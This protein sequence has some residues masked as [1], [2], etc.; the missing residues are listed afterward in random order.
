MNFGQ[1]DNGIM[2][3][4]WGDYET[5]RVLADVMKHHAIVTLKKGQWTEKLRMNVE[6]ASGTGWT[7]KNGNVTKTVDDAIV[8]LLT[9]T[10]LP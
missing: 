5:N 9:L 7:I 3:G 6:D 8:V 1:I 2:K 4:A 10:S